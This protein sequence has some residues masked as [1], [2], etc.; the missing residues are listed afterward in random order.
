MEICKF[1]ILQYYKR[2]ELFD[3]RQLE[4]YIQCLKNNVLKNYSGPLSAKQCV[5]ANFSF[6]PNALH[7]DNLPKVPECL[8]ILNTTER[9]PKITE[10][11]WE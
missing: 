2:R 3:L 10:D 8:Q 4:L 1:C 5:P 6:E 9:V 7:V 11:S